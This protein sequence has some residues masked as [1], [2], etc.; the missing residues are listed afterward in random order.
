M[1]YVPPN[2][3]RKRSKSPYSRFLLNS[4]GK[5]LSNRE[6]ALYP[7]KLNRL[8][9]EKKEQENINKKTKC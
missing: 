1:L 6:K 3:I 5:E 7:H 8:R 9:D 4:W 2:N